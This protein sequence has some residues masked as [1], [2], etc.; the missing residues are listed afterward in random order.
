[1]MMEIYDT[2][3]DNNYFFRKEITFI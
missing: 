2:H 1:M 3:I